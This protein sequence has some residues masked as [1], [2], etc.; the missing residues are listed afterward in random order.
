MQFNHPKEITEE[1]KKACKR[2][3]DAGFILY[4][5]SVLLK[6]VNDNIKT[7]EELFKRLLSIKVRPYYL[8]HCMPVLGTKHL[9]TTVKKGV[10]LMQKL[11]GRISGLAIPQYIIAS[12]EGGKIPIPYRDIKF[13]DGKVKTVNYEDKE[14]IYCE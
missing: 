13:L 12:K 3:S 2:L 1:S 10:K 11:Q 4:N 5:Q 14:I 9:R 8:Y 7:L 6:G